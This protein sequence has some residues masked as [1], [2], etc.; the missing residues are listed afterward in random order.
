MNKKLR[1]AISASIACT[2]LFLSLTPASA[3]PEFAKKEKTGCVTC[4]V[5]VKSKELNATGKCY[6]EKK[7]LT[8]C[9]T[10]TK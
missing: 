8:E 3:K 1:F 10:E 2:G 5:S 7:S 9:K 4:H 6:G